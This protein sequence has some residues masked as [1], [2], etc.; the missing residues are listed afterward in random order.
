MPSPYET[1]GVPKDATIAQIKN[2]FRKRAKVSHPDAGGSAQ[3]FDKL[4]R[5][6]AVLIDPKRRE[7]FDKTGVIDEVIPDNSANQAVGIVV[8]AFM[9]AANQFA[10]G[11]IYDPARCDMVQFAARWIE[12]QINKLRL[13]RQKGESVVSTLRKIEKRLSVKKKANP[14]LKKATAG[15]ADMISRDLERLTGAI[16]SHEEALKLLGDYSFE[17]L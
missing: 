15:Q 13:D 9:V 4:C 3:D 8:M 5:A 6:N 2:A 12:T 1:L 17:P 7:K 10:D 14:L 16:S 11:Q